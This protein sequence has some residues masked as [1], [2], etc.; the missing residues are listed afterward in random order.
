MFNLSK[1]PCRLGTNL[2]GR[3]QLHGDE[4]VAAMDVDLIDIMLDAAELNELLHEP[5]AHNLLFAAAANGKP[6]EPV[7]Q[8]IKALKL[9]DKIE[10]AS[11][12]IELAGD[13]TV[14]L[15]NCKLA[16][17]EVAP[18]VGGLSAMSFQ[19]QSVPKLDSSLARLF[20]KLDCEVRVTL[21]ANH[22]KQE[23][24]PL[25]APAGTIAGNGAMDGVDGPTQDARMRKRLA[26]KRASAGAARNA[27]RA[28]R[29]SGP[30]PTA[31]H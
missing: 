21:R 22:G 27:K 9:K 25:G 2:N 1:R 30:F 6:A 24:L 8:N 13:A 12:T 16:R 10:G 4:P 15:T 19:I 28:K 31:E 26:A 23:P 18:Q 5:H 20:E 17:I 7:F 29:A 3:R 11:V 14:K